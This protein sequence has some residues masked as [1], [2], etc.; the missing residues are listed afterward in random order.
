MRGVA[1]GASTI[2]CPLFLSH[3][4]ELR[5]DQRGHLHGDPLFLGTAGPTAPI[6]WAQVLQARLQP[7]TPRVG[8][9]RLVVPGLAFIDR[10]VQDV[11]DRA[12]GPALAMGTPGRQALLG[13]A[14][15][16]GVGA[17]LLFHPPPVHLLHDRGF[18]RID[19]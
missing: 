1:S 11:D 14:L 13:Q 19:D 5:V 10:V 4:P 6:A 18:A 7:R 15:L 12:L 2:G 8:H 17:E 16:N 9:L 3:P